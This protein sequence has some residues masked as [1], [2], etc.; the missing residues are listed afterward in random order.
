[1]MNNA[2][3]ISYIPVS[4]FIRCT[5]VNDVM[6]TYKNL[7]HATRMYHYRQFLTILLLVSSLLLF[8]G[9]GHDT[10]AALGRLLVPSSHHLLVPQRTT[11]L[12]SLNIY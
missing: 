7:L 10:A 12:N 4:S 3:I 11:A 1:M 2:I 8:L 9:F 6:A 5:D